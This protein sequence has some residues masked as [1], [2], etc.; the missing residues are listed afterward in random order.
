MIAFFVLSFKPL[1]NETGEPIIDIGRLRETGDGR[2]ITINQFVIIGGIILVYEMGLMLL[3]GKKRGRY[4]PWNLWY[5]LLIYDINK[6][7][8]EGKELTRE[9]RKRNRK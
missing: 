9:W 6:K 1:L 2:I 5:R 8:E 4:L 3:E 7:L